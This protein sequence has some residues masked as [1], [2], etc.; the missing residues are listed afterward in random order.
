[1]ALTELQI[2]QAKPDIKDFYLTDEK[3]LR[4]LVRTTGSKTWQLP[5]RQLH[6]GKED[7]FTIGACPEISLKDARAER[8]KARAV[9]T[10]G[11][12]PNATKAAS[13]LNSENTFEAIAMEWFATISPT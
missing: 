12:Y 13:K 3:G 4:L 5:Y 9:L 6:S 11:I 1:M 7:I 10:K 8:D 2:K